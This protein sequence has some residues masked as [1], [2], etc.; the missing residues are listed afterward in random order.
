MQ[1]KQ[2]KRQKMQA[3]QGFG[4]AFI[5][6]NGASKAAHPAK[7]AFNHPASWQQDKAALGTGQLLEAKSHLQRMLQEIPLTDDERAAVDDGLEAVAKLSA[8]LLDIPTP[9]GPTPRQ[10]TGDFVPLAAIEFRSTEKG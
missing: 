6:T 9:A 2:G 1:H 7:A 5:V 8:Q 3:F 10:L 4:Q